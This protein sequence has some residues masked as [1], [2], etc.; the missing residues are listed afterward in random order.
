[1]RKTNLNSKEM[2]KKNTFEFWA[3]DEKGCKWNECV[4][5]K[6]SRASKVK[7]LITQK[8]GINIEKCQDFGMREIN[9][10]N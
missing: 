7:K 3:I 10:N 2:S 4:T 9:I 5:T 1:M 6:S 8:Y